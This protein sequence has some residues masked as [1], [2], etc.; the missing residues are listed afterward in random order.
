MQRNQYWSLSQT[1]PTSARE[2]I[3]V[4]A[5]T[6]FCRNGIAATGIDTVTEKAGTAKATLYKHFASKQELTVAVLEAEG[7]VWRNWFFAKLRGIE[8]PAEA[9]ILAM[10]DVYEDWFSH[11]DFYGCPFINAV[12][13]VDSKDCQ[14]RAAAE[15]HKER[16]KTWITAIAMELGARDPADFTRAMVV[17][18]DGAI[19]AAQHSRDPSFA[20]TAKMLARHYVQDLVANRA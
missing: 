14:I 18:I 17:L 12:G 5:A 6:L 13:E 11:P 7:E 19:V 10:F 4:A 20:G 9:R 8:G 16:I 1:T 2:R 3:L 15:R